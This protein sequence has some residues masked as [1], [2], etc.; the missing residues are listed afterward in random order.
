MHLHL[1]LNTTHA[2]TYTN[3]SLLFIVT[4]WTAENIVLHQARLDEHYTGKNTF[5]HTMLYVHL[6]EPGTA[7]AWQSLSQHRIGNRNQ[8]EE[9]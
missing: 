7:L 5:L 1:Y 9:K 2:W 8:K 4:V 6:K 3:A